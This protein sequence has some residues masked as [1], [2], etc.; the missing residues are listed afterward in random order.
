MDSMPTVDIVFPVYWDNLHQIEKYVVSVSD[1]CKSHLKNYSWNLVLGVNG[2]KPEE[3]K[4][5]FL[6]L[7]KTNERLRYVY[8]PTPGKGAGLKAAW[9][10]STADILA[11]MDIDL[12]VDLEAL[13]ELLRG[14]ESSDICIGNRYHKDSKVQRSFSRKLTSWFYHKI[15]QRFLLGTKCGDLH[16]GF[17]AFRRPVAQKLLPH[18]QDPG[19]YFDSEIM[20]LAEKLGYTIKTIPVVWKEGFVSGLA[21][22]R[23][24]PAFLLKTIELRLRHLPEEARKN[25]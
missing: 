19:W 10:E 17:K 14:V 12:A 16:C 24:I 15:I 6:R 7:S 18:V 21:L 2:A 8:T 3:I 13:P 11:Y 1:F 23:V 20:I 9:T 25:S 22:K 4:E 5:L